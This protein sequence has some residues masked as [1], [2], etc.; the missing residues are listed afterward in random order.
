MPVLP[1][2]RYR[3]S[4]W[5]RTSDAGLVMRANFYLDAKHDFPQVPIP[6]TADGAWHEY[7]VTLPTGDFPLSVRPFLRLWLINQAGSVDVDDV[8]IELADGALERMPSGQL[9]EVEEQ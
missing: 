9:G 3:L 4:F 1:H 2:A 6:L 5:A 7:T 8:H